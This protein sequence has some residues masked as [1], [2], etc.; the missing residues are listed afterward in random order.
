MNA[1]KAI[2]DASQ[3]GATQ[4]RWDLRNRRAR[5]KLRNC[6]TYV[7]QELRSERDKACQKPGPPHHERKIV[8]DQ[9]DAV[10]VEL[11]VGSLCRSAVGVPGDRRWLVN[12]R[13]SKQE[14][15]REKQ[16]ILRG[17]RSR[18]GTQIR[19]KASNVFKGMDQL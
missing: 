17:T 13:V 2:R 5:T 10:G 15:L 4:S 7:A 1:G 14:K 3:L 16:R 11:L 19:C 6:R 18:A 12:E 9:A 8:G